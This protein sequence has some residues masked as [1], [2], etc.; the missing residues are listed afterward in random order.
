MSRKVFAVKSTMVEKSIFYDTAHFRYSNSKCIFA[1]LTPSLGTTFAHLF[2][3]ACKDWVEQF[4][5]PR[6]TC[7]EKLQRI[8]VRKLDK[9][10]KLLHGI[11]ERKCDIYLLLISLR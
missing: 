1:I 2:L 11:N 7:N 3:R 6:L 9:Y 4:C 8:P 5:L 10:L